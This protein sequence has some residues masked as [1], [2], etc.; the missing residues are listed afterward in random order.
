MT[1]ARLSVWCDDPHYVKAYTD[2]TPYTC[3]YAVTATFTD[4]TQQ[5]S[6]GTTDPPTNAGPITAADVNFGKEIASATL[7][8][9]DCTP[10]PQASEPRGDSKD[11]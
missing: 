10:Q 3:V 1:L 5:A 11:R 9:W 2:S 6:D 4:A 8:Q 7:D